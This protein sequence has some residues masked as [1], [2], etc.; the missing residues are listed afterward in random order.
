[1]EEII[2]CQANNNGA[3]GGTAGFDLQ[4]GGAVGTVCTLTGCT[5]MNNSALDGI[6]IEIPNTVEPD[7]AS[8]GNRVG[9]HVAS[10][11]NNLQSCVATNNSFGFYLHFLDKHTKCASRMCFV[12]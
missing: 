10:S 1:M 7:C 2:N 3:A 4:D 12:F 6:N 11:N 5:A 8:I 9:F